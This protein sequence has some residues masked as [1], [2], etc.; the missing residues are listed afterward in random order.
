M[1][2]DDPRRHPMFEPL[3]L[4]QLL[5]AGQLDATFGSG[6]T[7]VKND[8]L[9]YTRDVAVHADGRIVVAAFD[10][11]FNGLALLRYRP[12]GSPDPT[13]GGGDGAATDVGGLVDASSVAV[14]PDGRILVAGY[15]EG[16]Q[17]QVLQR[18]NADGTLDTSFGNAGTRELPGGGTWLLNG[19]GP[20]RSI[21][22]GAFN[23]GQA[24]IFVQA[25]GRIVVA[26]STPQA[27]NEGTDLAVMRLTADGQLDPTFGGGDGT[28]THDLGGSEGLTD[29]L[30]Q[31]DGKIVIA[32][33]RL[34]ITDDPAAIGGPGSIV[35]TDGAGTISIKDPSA[36]ILRLNADGSRDASFGNNG[37]VIE[38]L[39]A[40]MTW[41]RSIALDA[42]GRLLV[43][44]RSE[45]E[46]RPPAQWRNVLLRYDAAGNRDASFGAGGLVE[47][48]GGDHLYAD[49]FLQSDGKVLLT[50][51]RGDPGMGASVA[52]VKRLTPDG[53]AD[54]T[55]GAGGVAEVA[56]GVSASFAVGTILADGS[57]IVA[58]AA[59]KPFVGGSIEH[60]DVLVARFQ[61]D[62]ATTAT[63][64]GVKQSAPTLSRH[65]RHLRHLRQLK[66]NKK[67]RSPKRRAMELAAKERAEAEAAKAR[68]ATTPF[69]AGTPIGLCLP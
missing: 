6:G 27:N 16:R 47:L 40:D 52:I 59:T 3:E 38:K 24:Q 69:N 58:G 65:E 44:G 57:V 51:K 30:V 42:D 8:G 1:R 60:A 21:Q 12:D 33:S 31:P 45:T 37:V 25:D 56:T 64:T 32:G 43:L 23:T 4:R 7:I 46:A 63:T 17:K 34:T 29:L 15:L 5:S 68:Q 2:T 18:F 11:D 39:G 67:P 61:G 66:K 62:A 26:A 50:G 28:V 13:F 10:D 49:L 22:T 19:N 20:V 35:A 41:A 48:E 55:W 36:V 54:T 14:L 9:S 53:A